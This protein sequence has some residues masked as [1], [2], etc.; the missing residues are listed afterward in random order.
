MGSNRFAQLHFGKGWI[1][2]YSGYNNFAEISKSYKDIYTFH[3]WSLTILFFL[4]IIHGFN[5]FSRGPQP[6]LSPRI[7]SIIVFWLQMTES[8]LSLHD[9]RKDGVQ[10]AWKRY[11]W[12]FHVDFGKSSKYTDLVQLLCNLHLRLFCVFH[13]SQELKQGKTSQSSGASKQQPEFAAYFSSSPITLR[14]IILLKTL[15]NST[16]SISV[17]LN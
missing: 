11:L 4:R 2:H 12:K 8:A 17:N 1:Y 16:L 5:L 3:W 13:I 9:E 15:Q 10:D 7:V 6:Y 14:L